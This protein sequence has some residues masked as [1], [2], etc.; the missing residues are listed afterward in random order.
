MRPAFRRIQINELQPASVSVCVVNE[1]AARQSQIK[2]ENLLLLIL[3][4][5]KG[6]LQSV[7]VFV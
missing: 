7:S 1:Q 5:T 6:F 2:T 4:E 3:I